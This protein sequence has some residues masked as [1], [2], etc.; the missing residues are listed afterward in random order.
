[1]SPANELY[2]SAL[3]IIAARLFWSYTNSGNGGTTLVT[4][5]RSVSLLLSRHHANFGL[6]LVSHESMIINFVSIRY[7][8]SQKDSTVKYY[9]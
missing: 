7:L 1:M 4:G 6:A 5:N 8:S 9:L 2:K 3:R